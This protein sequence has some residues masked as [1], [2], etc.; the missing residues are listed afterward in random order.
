[1]SGDTVERSV[2]N[3]EG[4]NEKGEWRQKLERLVA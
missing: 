1:M 2:K 3:V 4:D